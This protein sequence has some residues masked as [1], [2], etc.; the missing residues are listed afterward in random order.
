[1]RCR[2]MQSTVMFHHP[3]RLPGLIGPQPPGTYRLV[4]NQEEVH[5]VSFVTFHTALI[6]LEIPTSGGSAVL[7]V[8]IRPAT[9]DQCVRG[10]RR[11]PKRIGL[12]RC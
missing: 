5:G 8:P 2:T 11:L 9:L 4:I 7:Q 3:F 12:P 6:V 10:D 1:M